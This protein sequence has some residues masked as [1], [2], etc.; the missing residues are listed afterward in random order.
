MVRWDLAL[1]CLHKAVQGVDVDCKDCFCDGLKSIEVSR[2]DYDNR[3]WSFH[4]V[5]VG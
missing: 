2:A 4:L 3:F 1:K 5:L